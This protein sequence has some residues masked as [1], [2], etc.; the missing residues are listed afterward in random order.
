MVAKIDKGVS[1]FAKAVCGITFAAFLAMMLIIMIDVVS[2][3][4]TGNSLQ[5]TYEIVERLLMM[6][7]FASIAYT[8]TEH[9]HVHVTMLISHL[10]L[11]PALII[12]GITS[13]L[14]VAAILMIAYASFLQSQFSYAQHTTTGVLFIPLFPF[15]IAETLGM[16][17]F[18]LAVIWD[19]IKCFIALGNEEVAESIRS[20]WD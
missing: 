15:Y 13:L 1:I 10:P 3:T 17:I 2:R 12:N 6:G 19:T 5:G 9:G 7:V 11:K 4:I 18:S 14:S 16:I 20:T 8:Q